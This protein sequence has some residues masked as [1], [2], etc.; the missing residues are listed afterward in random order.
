[1]P[2]GLITPAYEHHPIPEITFLNLY[3][4]CRPSAAESKEPHLRRTFVALALLAGA[5]EAE[6]AGEL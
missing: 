4:I 6:T 5:S 3:N 2:Q 1:V